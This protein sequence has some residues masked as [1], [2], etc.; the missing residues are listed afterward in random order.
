MR[1]TTLVRRARAD[2][3]KCGLGLYFRFPASVGAVQG[4]VEMISQGFFRGRSYRN[5]ARRLGTF[6]RRRT[7]RRPR[8]RRYAP[9]RDASRKARKRAASSERR[10]PSAV[11]GRSGG[12]AQRALSPRRRPIGR[13]AERARRPA[14]VL[15]SARL[16][17]TLAH[18]GRR[19]HAQGKRAGRR[20][21]ARGRVGARCGRFRLAF[22]ERCACTS[23]SRRLQRN[24]NLPGGPQIWAL[25]AWRP[26]YQSVRTA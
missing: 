18:T 6:A 15:R 11:G 5:C 7:V 4:R 14:G 13:G 25:R 17:S 3:E 21:R 1:D 19:A 2:R 24:C 23:R 26:H 22:R 9:G 16:R 8:E 12:P 10:C 20:D